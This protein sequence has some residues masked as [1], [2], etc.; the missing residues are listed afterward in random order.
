[1][2]REGRQHGTVRITKTT[3]TA[4]SSDAACTKAH[5]KPTGHSK[6]AGKCKRARCVRCHSSPASKSRHKAKGTY[7]LKCSDVALNHRL[8]SWRVVDDRD[9]ISAKCSGASASASGML[10]ALLMGSCSGE[11]YD[12]DDDYDDH[13]ESMDIDEENIDIDDEDEEEEEEDMEFCEVGFVWEYEDEEG[14]CV[15]DEM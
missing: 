10:D 2:K 6:P 4:S 9:E 3:T 5:R 14:W 12:D 13:G 11:R 7:K 15:V 1:M 8:V